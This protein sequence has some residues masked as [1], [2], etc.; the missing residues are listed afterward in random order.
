M[1]NLKNFVCVMVRTIHYKDEILKSS[2]SLWEDGAAW[3]GRSIMG[4]AVH[5]EKE[6]Q[7]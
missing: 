3:Y 4:K 2:G 7:Q 1:I 5:Y 6:T